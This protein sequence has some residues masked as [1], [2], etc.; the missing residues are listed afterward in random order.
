MTTKY[1]SPDDHIARHIKPSLI[2]RDEEL[3]AIGIFP[4]A[5]ALREDERDLSVNWLEF[6][7]GS[8]FEQLKQIMEHTE[9]TMNARHGFGV[10]SV[11]SFIESCASQGS[12][13]RIIHEPT[14]GNPAHS[15]VHQYPRDRNELM[16]ILANLASRRLTMVGDLRNIPSADK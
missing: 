6:F 7:S 1:L 8:P 10:L 15:S 12:K 16:A 4:Q 2:M 9:L 3:K 14:A 11:G 5:F 13:V